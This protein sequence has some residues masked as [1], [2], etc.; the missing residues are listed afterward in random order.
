M[1]HDIDT[2]GTKNEGPNAARRKAPATPTTA[3]VGAFCA[4]QA[5]IAAFGAFL[6]HSGV[7]ARPSAPLPSVDQRWSYIKLGGKRTRV[8]ADDPLGQSVFL[9]SEEKP[10]CLLVYP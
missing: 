10:C 7:E 9:S 1:R 6:A 8:M 5:K 2:F 3:L 4:E